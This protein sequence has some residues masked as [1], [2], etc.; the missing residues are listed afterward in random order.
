[1]Y[2]R[3]NKESSYEIEAK[4]CLKLVD[5]EDLVVRISWNDSVVNELH[6]N[7]RKYLLLKSNKCTKINQ[8][9]ALET[10]NGKSVFNYKNQ[11][12]KLV[13]P[14]KFTNSQVKINAQVFSKE[15]N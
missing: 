4:S 7:K 6:R 1:M 11:S 5:F 13:Q 9:E 2:R 10:Q 14:N 3:N 15:V 8:S 12:R